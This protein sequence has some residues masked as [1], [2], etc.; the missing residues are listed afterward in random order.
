VHCWRG[1]DRTGTIIACYRIQHDGWSSRQ[2]LKE[3]EQRGLSHAE[4]GMRSFILKFS[5][6][7]LPAP[8]ALNK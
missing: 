1:K 8:F 2:A 6:L 5:P 3:A 4:F 7:D